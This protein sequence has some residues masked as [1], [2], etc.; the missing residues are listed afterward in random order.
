[1]KAWQLCLL[2]SVTMTSHNASADANRWCGLA[3]LVLSLWC[4]VFPEKGE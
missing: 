3:L 1:M 4:A 2:L